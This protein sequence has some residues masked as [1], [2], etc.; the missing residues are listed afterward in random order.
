MLDDLA[1]L[2][3]NVLVYALFT[4][5]EHHA[6]ARALI[7]RGQTGVIGIVVTPQILAEFYAIITNP[8][9]VTQPLTPA[10]AIAEVQKYLAEFA[11]L[12]V[13]PDVVDRWAEL[14]MRH[15][16]VGGDI[17]DL[18]LIATMIGNGVTTIYTFNDRDFAWCNQIEVRVPT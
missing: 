7:A 9:R 14:A 2:D 12:P 17:Y 5:A 18:Q 10:D 13:P 15:A 4:D 16:V 1:L 3:T 8:R 11:V 6:A